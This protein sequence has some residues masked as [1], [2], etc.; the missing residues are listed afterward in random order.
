DG[1]TLVSTLND[2]KSE[3]FDR[4]MHAGDKDSTNKHEKSLAKKDSSESTGK[5]PDLG[6]LMIREILESTGLP[7][8]T[9][10]KKE[11]DDAIARNAE[12]S[13]KWKSIGNGYVNGI[14]MPGLLL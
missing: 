13:R 4:A 12:R 14:E 8:A 6:E 9:N 3:L 11:V 7:K 5:E 10:L 2:H 1:A